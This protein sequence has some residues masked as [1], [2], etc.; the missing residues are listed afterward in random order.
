MG[1]TLIDR[2]ERAS[3][4]DPVGGSLQRAVRSALRSQW[5]RDA[6][7]GVWLGH[8][9][10]PAM[11]QAPIGAWLSA[12]VLD[13]VPGHKR[14]ATTLLAAGTVA[15][16]PTAVVGAN[17][18]ASL[19][20]EQRRVG[21]I[22]ATSNTAALCLFTGSL[23]AR[24]RG[25][26]R[27]GRVLTLA[28][29]GLATAGAYLGGHLSYRQGA[30]VSHAEP[31]LRLLP[32]GWQVVGETSEFAEATPVVRHIGDVPVVVYRRGDRFTV[33]VERCA[34]QGGPL[35]DGALTEVDG[36]RCVVCP[37][38]GSTFRLVD[39]SVVHGPAATNQPALAVRVT[40]NRLEA[41]QP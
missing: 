34:H 2:L 33:L 1:M 36:E 17:D 18:W 14:A 13:A 27:S 8:P 11:V 20:A 12:A 35:G 7:H 16:L 5:L 29:L 40:D 21:L 19:A 41:R 30:G 9:L 26:H 39:G 23:I 37:W 15:A 38:H 25:R 32:A 22:H 6:L 10:H 4:L 24:L 31:W 3:W 28:G